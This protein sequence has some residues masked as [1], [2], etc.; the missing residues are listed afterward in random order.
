MEGM[1]QSSPFL[2]MQDVETQIKALLRAVD[3]ELLE[4]DEKKAVAALRRLAVDVRL[5]I[6]DYELSETR[7]EQLAKAGQAKHGL[8]K[9]QANVVAASSIFGPAD[10][11]QL[12]ARLQHVVSRL[13]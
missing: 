9:I 4:L 11:A 2:A 7:A 8:E 10:V 6:R 1:E 3:T 5:D 12:D 13:L